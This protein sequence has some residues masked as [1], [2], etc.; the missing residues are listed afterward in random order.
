MWYF[1]LNINTLFHFSDYG[2]QS[3]D[4]LTNNHPEYILPTITIS[5]NLKEFDHFFDEP[6]KTKDD[7]IKDSWSFS[8]NYMPQ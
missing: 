5:E 7:M 3:H 6:E 2:N 1:E 4:Q 8:W